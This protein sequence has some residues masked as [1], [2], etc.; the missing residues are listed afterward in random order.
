MRS[1][2]FERRKIVF[3][4]GR[5]RSLMQG[6]QVVVFKKPGHQQLPAIS[7]GKTIRRETFS[8]PFRR[9]ADCLPD[10]W[11]ALTFRPGIETGSDYG[12]RWVGIGSTKRRASRLELRERR[13]SA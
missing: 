2:A 6:A 1:E 4:V 5:D 11:L 13:R 3:D 9:L 12:R 7:T 10:A 8:R